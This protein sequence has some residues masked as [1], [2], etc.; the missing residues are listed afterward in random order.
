MSSTATP[1]AVVSSPTRLLEIAWW[2]IRWFLLAIRRIVVLTLK[3][4][5]GIVGSCVVLIGVLLIAVVV[6]QTIKESKKVVPPPPAFPENWIAD[7][8]A[9]RDYIADSYANL[10]WSIAE[11]RIDPYRL[12]VQTLEAI[13]NARNDDEAR[14]ELYRFVNVFHDPH[15]ALLEPGPPGHWYDNLREWAKRPRSTTR[16]KAACAALG[17]QSG[18]RWLSF[19][20]PE[21]LE[22]FGAFQKLESESFRVGVITLGAGRFGFIRIP[23]FTVTDYPEACERVWPKVARDVGFLKGCDAACKNKVVYL[24]QGEL[25]DE[26][27]RE[28]VR[29]ASRRIDV[30]VVDVTGNPGGSVDLSHLMATTLTTSPL[31]GEGTVIVKN[32]LARSWLRWMSVDLSGALTAKGVPSAIHRWIQEGSN[33]T[34]SLMEEFLGT[35]CDRRPWF[36]QPMM[37]D[38]SRLTTGRLF[39]AGLFAEPPQNLRLSRELRNDIFGPWLRESTPERVWGGSLIV[40]TSRN[41]CSAAEAF[42]KTLHDHAGALLLGERTDG[43]GG[44]WMLGDE[45]FA[46]P[47]SKLR[48]AAPDHVLFLKDGR[49]ARFGIEPD[50]CL[51]WT[52][53]TSLFSKAAVML[54]TLNRF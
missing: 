47:Y 48:V 36:T 8:E 50:V 16:P 13:R 2:F 30:L 5:A 25:V 22:R 27:S 21:A 4:I 19:V 44:G 35:Q 54:R 26:L 38:C 39:E 37:P 12:N 45:R 1:R 40:M 33:R 32:S 31:P 53:G 41:T 34:E 10:E 23:T 6:D 24:V 52:P 14:R 3:T 49:N 46:L 29:L 51:D 15:L 11:S 43:A 9:M 28:V 42:A 20:T 17:F 7:Y 18:R